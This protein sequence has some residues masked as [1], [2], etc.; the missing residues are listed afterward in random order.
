MTLLDIFT[1]LE[2]MWIG[3]AIRTS[4]WLFPFIEAIH[5]V[6]LALLGGTVLVVDFRLL[7]ITLR[8]QSMQVVLRN[9]RPYFLLALG[10]MFATGI[11]LALS[12]MIKLYYN[13]SWW[14]KVSALGLAIL[15]TFLVR[16]PLVRRGEAPRMAMGCIALVSLALWFTVAGAGRWI[17]FS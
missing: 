1:R 3:E 12:E 15:F 10:T 13:F 5:L 16:D 7:G 6:G 11:P 9:T 17:G 14:V 8:S 2:E 4:Y